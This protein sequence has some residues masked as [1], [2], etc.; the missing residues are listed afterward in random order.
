MIIDY[1]PREDNLRV[2]CVSLNDIDSGKYTYTQIKES[3]FEAI[4]LISESENE[5]IKNNRFFIYF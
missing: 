4:K 1:Y 5:K 2:F 3:A